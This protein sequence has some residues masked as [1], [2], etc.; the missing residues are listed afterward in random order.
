MQALIE[1]TKLFG[2]DED[3]AIKLASIFSTE[4]VLDKNDFF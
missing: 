3:Q 2:L 1:K 4:I